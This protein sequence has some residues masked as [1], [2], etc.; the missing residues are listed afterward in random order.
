MRISKTRRRRGKILADGEEDWLSPLAEH[1]QHAGLSVP[2]GGNDGDRLLSELAK[3]FP[4]NHY[5]VVTADNAD[6]KKA[7]FKK[8]A[9]KALVVD[10]SIPQGVRKA[11]REAREKIFR[12]RIVAVLGRAGKTIDPDATRRLLEYTGD[13]LR[14]LSGSLEKLIDFTGPRNAIAATDIRDVLKKTRQDPIFEFTGAVM[15]RNAKE[16]ITQMAR[17]LDGG[18]HPLQV[19]SALVNQVRKLV[20]AR[21]FQSGPKGSCWVPGMRY[22][23]FNRDVLP[24]LL[25]WEGV[26]KEAVRSWVADSGSRK[27][28]DSDLLFAGNGKSAYPVFLLLQKAE[29]FRPHEPRDFLCMLADLDY[30]IKSGAHSDPRLAI[31]KAVLTLCTPTDPR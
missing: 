21:D 9:E 12:E 18:I 10:C 2:A 28:K 1:C 20:A 3:G 22:D 29:R 16:A 25:E 24:T 15:D 8:L 31:E 27:K 26:K 4:A 11:D 17:L 23:A 13:D 19:L 30:R 14:T 6:R 5:L 7:L